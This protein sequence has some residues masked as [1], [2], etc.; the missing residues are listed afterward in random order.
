MAIVAAHAAKKT[1]RV[2]YCG[3]KPYVTVKVD[4]SGTIAT[5]TGIAI[6]ATQARTRYAGRQPVGGFTGDSV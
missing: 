6:T 1:Y 5:G 3:Q 4:F 2:G